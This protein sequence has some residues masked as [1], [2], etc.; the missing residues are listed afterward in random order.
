MQTND[1]ILLII[2]IFSLLTG[3]ANKMRTLYL[4]LIWMIAFIGVAIAVYTAPAHYYWSS[5]EALFIA[6]V[7]IAEIKDTTLHSTLILLAASTTFT[8]DVAA[9]FGV[10]CRNMFACFTRKLDS[11]CV[12]IV[13]R[14][15]RHFLRSTS[16]SPKNRKR[17]K[18]KKYA[19]SKRSLRQSRKN[20][21]VLS[22]NDWRPGSS[23]RWELRD[24]QRR[25]PHVCLDGIPQRKRLRPPQFTLGCHK[26]SCFVV[27]SDGA[28]THHNFRPIKN[29]SAIMSRSSCGKS[30]RHHISICIASNRYLGITT[31]RRK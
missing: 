30:R 18:K 23:C 12:P 2:T 7:S 25:N 31:S 15:P 29:A 13:F 24:S 16:L 20:F 5:L 21:R 11:P 26:R 28:Y 17:S 8:H 19:C 4:K 22:E 1:T 3:V 14:S 6:S 9:Y 27:S 10:S